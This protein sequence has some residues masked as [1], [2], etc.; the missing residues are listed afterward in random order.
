VPTQGK[1]Q[2]LDGT[3]GTLVAAGIGCQHLR[4]CRWHA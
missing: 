3:Q 4:L 2:S 1:I